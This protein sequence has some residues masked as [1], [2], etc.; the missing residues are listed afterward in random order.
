[1]LLACYLLN[2]NPWSYSIRIV[3]LAVRVQFA[4]TAG[5]DQMKIF[6]LVEPGT[7]G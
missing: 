4:I 3:A 7:Q 1:M 5:V 6:Q 2:S